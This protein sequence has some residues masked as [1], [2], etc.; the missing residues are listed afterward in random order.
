M[1]LNDASIAKIENIDPGLQVKYLSS[2]N[3][4]TDQAIRRQKREENNRE[5]YGRRGKLAI[6]RETT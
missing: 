3:G 6:M 1:R 4:H 2:Y 5:P